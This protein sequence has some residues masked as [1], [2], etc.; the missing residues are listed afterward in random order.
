MKKRTEK[1]R[2]SHFVFS[3][4]V[5]NNKSNQEKRDE[6]RTRRIFSFLFFCLDDDDDDEGEEEVFSLLLF[7]KQKKEND[8]SIN[9]RVNDGQCCSK[10]VR[11]RPSSVTKNAQLIEIYPGKYKTEDF[12]YLNPFKFNRSMNWRELFAQEFL[13]LRR[14]ERN[15]LGSRQSLRN[16]VFAWLQL[17]ILSFD[18]FL[19][20]KWKCL[21]PNFFNVQ[22]TFSSSDVFTSVETNERNFLSF[23]QSF[24]DSLESGRTIHVEHIECLHV[25]RNIEDRITSWPSASIGGRGASSSSILVKSFSCWTSSRIVESSFFFFRSDLISFVVEYEFVSTDFFH[26]GNEIPLRTNIGHPLDIVTP[27]DPSLSISPRSLQN[28]AGHRGFNFHYVD[29][30]RYP[31]S[32]HY[33]ISHLHSSKDL[34]RSAENNYSRVKTNDRVLNWQYL[35]EW[36]GWKIHKK[37]VD[38]VSSPLMQRHPRVKT[39]T[40]PVDDHTGDIPLFSARLHRYRDRRIISKT[41]LSLVRHAQLMISSIGLNYCCW[42]LENMWTLVDFWDVCCSIY[43]KS[44]LMG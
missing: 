30:F 41:D 42:M 10:I 17:Y 29:S 44:I 18:A 25:F 37:S 4:F 31:S 36:H 16:D 35:P 28:D 5:W 26:E 7:F 22:R 19:A 20:K 39:N 13:V 40:G 2:L 6:W 9:Q 27:W 14:D 12:E 23:E 38:R 32:E 43:R 33:T 34:R 11:C 24:E 3:L 8:V 21:S 15:S 1:E